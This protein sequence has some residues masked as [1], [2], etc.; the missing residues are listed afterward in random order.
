MNSI[1]KL[2]DD[3]KMF[4]HGQVAIMHKLLRPHVI[5]LIKMPIVMPEDSPNAKLNGTKSWGA[6]VVTFDRYSESEKKLVL[7]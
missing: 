3:K 7:I 2:D 5:W 6:N 1:L 4:L